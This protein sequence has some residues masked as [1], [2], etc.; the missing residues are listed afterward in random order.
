M[1]L[2]GRWR[3]AGEAPCLWAWL[4]LEAREPGPV[5]EV[6]GSW[7]QLE[8]REPGPVVEVLGWARMGAVR[9]LTTQHVSRELLQQVR[10]HRGLRRLRV[11]E[12]HKSAG[13]GHMHY[14]A[15][16]QLARTLAG[17][18]EVEMC[19]AP[20]DKQQ[21]DSLFAALDL[22]SGAL[23]KLTIVRTVLFYVEPGLLARVVNRL[24]DVTLVKVGL[25]RQQAE[26]ILR[27]VRLGS[28]L[29][30]LNIASNT[31]FLATVEPG[32]LAAAVNRLQEFDMSDTGLTREQVLEGS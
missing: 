6:L 4:Q 29:R 16:A 5:V 27:Q 15:F 1:L 9:S 17:L 11:T 23:R 28:A 21:I 8:A 3:E 22:D 2:S 10:Q 13:G 19:G 20:L 26:A 18:E 32:L 12:L 7:L 14:G 24:E 25:N 30:R 31:R